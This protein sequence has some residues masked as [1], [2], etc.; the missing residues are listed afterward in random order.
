[1]G[2]TEEQ[3]ERAKE[4]NIPESMYRNREWQKEQRYKKNNPMPDDMYDRV[5]GLSKEGYYN[6]NKEWNYGD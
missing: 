4:K 1:M 6:D 3:I 2:F 5:N